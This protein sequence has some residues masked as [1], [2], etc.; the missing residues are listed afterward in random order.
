[1]WTETES[2]TAPRRCQGTESKLCCSWWQLCDGTQSLKGM[3]KLPRIDKSSCKHCIQNG[4]RTPISS[5]RIQVLLGKPITGIPPQDPGPDVRC[6]EASSAGS[7]SE[8]RG[9]TRTGD[10]FG[11]G[12]VSKSRSAPRK[13]RAPSEYDNPPEFPPKDEDHVKSAEQPLKHSTI[14]RD[15]TF[16]IQV[17]EARLAAP[18]KET[19]ALNS[20]RAT[21]EAE[22]KFM[23]SRLGLEHLKL[24][25]TP[26]ARLSRQARRIQI[27]RVAAG[28]LS[29]LEN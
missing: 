9:Y 4:P 27:R 25:S 13:P 23:V 20:G 12:S 26:R 21:A 1:M 7:E 28:N 29:G 17:I 6:S 22:D 10:T 11:F 3:Q 18:A 5:P 15:Q 19:N 2:Q 14:L 24:W 8:A 16:K